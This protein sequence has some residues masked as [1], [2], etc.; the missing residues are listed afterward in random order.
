[1][2]RAVLCTCSAKGGGSNSFMARCTKSLPGNDFDDRF[3][4]AKN[5]T[6]IRAKQPVSRE[7]IAELEQRFNFAFPPE[8]VEHYLLHNGGR[9]EAKYLVKDDVTFILR[10]FHP[11]KHG[12]PGCL[13]ESV[14]FDVKV[15]RKLLPAHLV[16]F[17]CDPG[18]D[19]FCF[20]TREEDY[21]A[22]WMYRW[23]YYDEPDRAVEFLA[24]SLPEFLAA[25]V[26]V[27]P[28]D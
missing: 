4:E 12:V 9:P 13:F 20:S 16:P 26:A 18:D 17:A 21:G 14:F 6:Y 5:V 25:L 2:P 15:D 8:F 19:Y 27:D 11:I 23:D 28:H 22:I 3:D 10:D 1:M 24:G 7:E